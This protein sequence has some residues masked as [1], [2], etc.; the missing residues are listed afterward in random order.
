MRERTLILMVLLLCGTIVLA[1]FLHAQ[2][3][4][5]DVVAVG[6]GGSNDSQGDIQVFL[7][8]HKTGQVW[9]QL[10]GVLVPMKRYTSEQAPTTASPSK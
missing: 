6:S 3:H 8:D 9:T 5:W 2:V 1:V 7:V 10:D 4:R